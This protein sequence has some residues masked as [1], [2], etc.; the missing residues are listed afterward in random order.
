[1]MYEPLQR[2]TGLFSPEVLN[3]EFVNTLVLLSLADSLA[4]SFPSA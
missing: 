4:P 2:L 3:H 1:M